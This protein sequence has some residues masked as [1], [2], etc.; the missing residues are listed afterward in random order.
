MP[1]LSGSERYDVRR[2]ETVAV[3]PST[4]Q[5][6]LNHLLIHAARRPVY[7]AEEKGNRLPRPERRGLRSPWGHSYLSATIGSTPSA[8]RED[9]ACAFGE[10]SSP[11]RREKGLV[12]HGFSWMGSAATQLISV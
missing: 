5:S 6:P 9:A 3:D 7:H 11:M 10:S 8:T 4:Q 2:I 1:G 12:A